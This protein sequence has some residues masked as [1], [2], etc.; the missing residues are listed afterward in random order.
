MRL[1]NYVK[2]NYNVTKSQL[3]DLYHDNRILVNDKLENLSYN[4][5]DGDVVTIDGKVVNNI[6]YVYYLYN[7][8]IGVVCT[9]DT[10]VTDNIISKLNLS[11]RVYSVGRLDKI[12]HGLLIIT[13]DGEFTHKLLN[14][15]CHIEKEYIVKVKNK[16]DKEFISK[17]EDNYLIKDKLTLNA[18]CKLIDDYTFS[19]I[20]KEGKY[21]QIRI[22]VKRNNNEVVDLF[23]YR[24]GNITIEYLENKEIK[25]VSNL[26][27][28]IF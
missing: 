28:I 17:M 3:M 20:L 2:N 21:H 19:I 15:K 24:I 6:N 13:N 7:K 12:S 9:N 14:P 23:R 10:L 25:E 26:K 22:M 27:D 8:P 4:I 5:K 18:K 11:T 1:Q 16:I